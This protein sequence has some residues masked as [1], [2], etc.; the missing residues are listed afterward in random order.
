MDEPIR[1]AMWSGPRNIS[2]AM[3]Y[4]FDNRPD[5]YATDEP[6]YASYLLRSGVNHPGAEEV[7]RGNDADFEE[8]TSMLNGTVPEGKE[9]W[10]QKHMCHHV[11]RDSDLSWLAGLSN[12]FLIRE[13]KEVI[14]SLSKITSSIDLWSIGL[15]QQRRIIEHV[16]NNTGKIPPI[17]DSKD[18]LMEPEGML[19]SLCQELGVEFMEEMTSWE[20]GPRSCDGNWAKYWYESVWQSSGFSKYSTS[21]EEIDYSL[22]SVLEDAREIYLSLWGMRL[23]A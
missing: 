21:Q 23:G 7:I 18:V 22:E 3:M 6:L 9:I 5:C 17:I 4:S 8:V 19:R 10:Y 12:C 14:L 11:P 15:P 16:T 20:P 2:T 1:V 13:P